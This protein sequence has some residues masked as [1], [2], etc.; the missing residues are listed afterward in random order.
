MTLGAGNGG[1]STFLFK[2]ING[3]SVYNT[4]VGVVY[5]SV[6]PTHKPPSASDAAA[7]LKNTGDDDKTH[8][9]GCHGYFNHL[10][11]SYDAGASPPHSVMYHLANVFTCGSTKSTHGINIPPAAADEKP[12][13]TVDDI[14]NPELKETLTVSN[15]SLHSYFATTNI[16]Y[17]AVV[18]NT[19]YGE[20]IVTYSAHSTV[21][22]TLKDAGQVGAL[23]KATW[24]FVVK[25]IADGYSKLGAMKLPDGF[26]TS[27][28][29]AAYAVG[30][31]SLDTIFLCLYNSEDAAVWSSASSSPDTASASQ[32]DGDGGGS[33]TPAPRAPVINTSGST[34]AP[35]LTTD[36]DAATSGDV[37]G[38]RTHLNGDDGV[39]SGATPGSSAVSIARAADS[40]GPDGATPGSSAV[41]IAH[42]ADSTGPVGAIFAPAVNGTPA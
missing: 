4:I 9:H 19:S 26:P 2:N 18:K 30:S 21:L 42:A 11:Y 15:G 38:Q 34:P 10:M 6:S 40:T 23:N 22:S 33:P 7:F 41:S 12:A 32:H 37:G 1:I 36:T 3:A 28:G 24:G 27:G 20:F 17:D 5:G 39:V 35:T 29:S 31:S 13:Y 16:V 8:P 14:D 25:T